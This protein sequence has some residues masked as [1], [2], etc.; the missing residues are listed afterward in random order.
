MFKHIIGQ[1]I[2]QLVILMLLVFYGDRF[3][4]EYADTLDD[5][6]IAKGHHWSVKY[7][8]GGLLSILF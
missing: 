1:S 4:P 7:S 5:D 3:I 6:I 2:Y 8:E